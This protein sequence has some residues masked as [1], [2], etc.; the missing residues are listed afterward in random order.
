M[1]HI[2]N[3]TVRDKVATADDAHYICGNSDFFVVFDFD[4]EWNEH[5][6]KT[7]R[8]VHED[9]T[10]YD[11]VFSGNKC[12]IPIISN[13]SSIKVG[14]YAGN[15]STTT[16]AYVRAERSILCGNGVPAAPPDDVYNQIMKLLND[17]TAGVVNP[18]DIEEAVAKYFEENPISESDPT[19]PEWAKQEEKPKYTASEVD[20]LSQ[21]DLQEAVNVALQ[22][23]E[24]SGMFNG[25]DGHTPEKG[26]DYYTEADKAEM[27]A[28]V[29]A[30]I[31]NGDEVAY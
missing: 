21:D 9:G 20:A 25:E 26:V 27:V 10:P 28:A 1:G 8:F 4:E 22:A 14:V 12:P 5:Q 31:P 7:A 3:I 18:Q 24:E 11:K 19:V 29:L 17:I 2:I 13:T 30:A 23:A 15:L 16:R 6:T